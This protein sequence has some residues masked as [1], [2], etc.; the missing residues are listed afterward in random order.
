L[1]S[2]LPPVYHLRYNCVP[3]HEVYPP[4]AWFASRKWVKTGLG[5]DLY[6]ARKHTQR[7]RPLPIHSDIRCCIKPAPAV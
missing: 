5:R 6:V 7:I 4:M 2:R 3:I 1:M